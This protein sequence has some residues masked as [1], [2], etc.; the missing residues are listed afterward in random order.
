MTRV[1]ALG[2]MLP[3]RRQ[4]CHIANAA[5]IAVSAAAAA[6]AATATRFRVNAASNRTENSVAAEGMQP[7]AI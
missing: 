2:V 4:S 1:I 3:A 6:A 7:T 5:P